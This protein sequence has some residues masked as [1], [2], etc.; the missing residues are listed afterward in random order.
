[1]VRYGNYKVAIPGKGLRKRGRF[2]VAGM[3]AGEIIA[4]V[5]MGVLLLGN[6]WRRQARQGKAIARRGLTRWLAYSDFVAFGIIM[7]GLVVMYLQ[8]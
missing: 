3:Q 6:M 4:L 7:V 8:R 2:E 5:G 1:M